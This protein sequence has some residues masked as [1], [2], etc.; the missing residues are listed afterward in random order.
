MAYS[1]FS[2]VSA[3]SIRASSA[4]LAPSLSLSRD[5]VCASFSRDSL[6][7]SVASAALSVSRP[8]ESSDLAHLSVLVSASARYLFVFSSSVPYLSSS[9][10][11]LFKAVLSFISS[12]LSFSTSPLWVFILPSKSETACSC[13]LYAS[14]FFPDIISTSTSFFFS[15]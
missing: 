10:A 3:Q 8:Y 4:F 5:S 6:T 13:A 15:S 12:A 14:E 9:A 11:A 2:A 1:N 7:S